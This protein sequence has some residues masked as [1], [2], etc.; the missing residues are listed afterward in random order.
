MKTYNVYTLGTKT[1]TRSQRTGNVVRTKRPNIHARKRT[2]TGK[3]I[4]MMIKRL[5]AQ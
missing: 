4:A 3:R 2:T 5:L 1:E